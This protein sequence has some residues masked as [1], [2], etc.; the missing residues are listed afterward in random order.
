[1][2]RPADLGGQ[3]GDPGAGQ[4]PGGL[5]TVAQV[6]LPGEKR[7][8][9]NQAHLAPQDVDQLR[10]LVDPRPPEPS[11]DRRDPRITGLRLAT[12]PEGRRSGHRAELI[13]PEG[14]PAPTGPFLGEEGRPSRGQPDRGGGDHH[15]W[16]QQGQA[17]EG[18]EDVHG[19]LS[20]SVGKNPRL[21]WHQSISRGG[22]SR[23]GRPDRRWADVLEIE[24][25]C[26]SVLNPCVFALTSC[27][28]R[29]ARKRGR[30]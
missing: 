12:N 1:M 15:D 16:G 23:V 30:R 11:A 5:P 18:A 14:S 24:I 4:Q 13:D 26:Q 20:G 2:L 28:S 27:A 3:P 22:D 25:S 17:D 6:V 10:Q 9:S 19:P 8:W 29:G 21:D 7:S